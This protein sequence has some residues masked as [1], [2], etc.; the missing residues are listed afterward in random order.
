MSHYL[1]DSRLANLGART[2]LGAYE[3]YQAHFQAITRRAKRCFEQRDWHGMQADAVARLELYKQIVDVTVGDVQRL[4]DDR[5]KDKVVWAGMKA[6]YSGLI[7]HLDTWELAETFFNSV[8]RRIFATVGVDPQIEFVTTDFATPPVAASSAV[9]RSYRQPGSV[10]RMIELILDDYAF[11]VAYEDRARDVALAVAAIEGHLQEVGGTAVVERVEMVGSVFYRGQGAYLIG[12]FFGRG[13]GEEGQLTP[14]VLALHN[15]ERGMVIDAVLLQ[16]D[17][18]SIL[19][20]FA[21]SYFHVLAP[22]P[23]DLVQFIKSIIPRKRTAE[24][25]ISIGFNKHGKTVLYRDLLHHLATTTDKFEIAEG[26]RGMVMSVFTLPQ[27]DYVFKLIKD[28]FAYPKKSTRQGVMAQYSFVFKHDR[29]GRL[30]DVQEFEHLELE[31]NRFSKALLAELE[32]MAAHTVDVGVDRVVI[33]HVYVERRVTPL[34][35]YLRGRDAA[36]A[37]AVVVDYGQAVKDLAAT[38]V[39]PGDMLLKN[40]GVTRHGRVIFYDYDE[41]SLLTACCFRRMPEPQSEEQILADEPW[42][43]VAENDFFPEEFGRFLG[44]PRSLLPVFMAHHGDLCDVAFWQQM[45]ARLEA[46]EV[47][48]IF[49]YAE[50]ARLRRG[51]GE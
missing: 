51:S 37:E 12:R 44:L 14:L 15:T 16:A 34:D 30:L 48:H 21:R 42:F 33:K 45:Q 13:T 17:Q 19:F 22:R 49:P 6:V 36:A 23:Y 43:P 24:I 4:L 1:S 47:I 41:L 29:A 18:V 3:A 26:A 35:I 11:G 40:F 8:T 5:M 27:Y 9:Y 31:R 46:G 32:S 10:Q 39:F 20:S 28:R 2:I 50:R 38:N 7:D 25:Y